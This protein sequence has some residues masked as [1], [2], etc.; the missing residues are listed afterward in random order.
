MQMDI[1]MLRSQK[2]APHMTFGWIIAQANGT[3]IVKGYGR[4]NGR[5]SSLR[6]EAAGIL[7]ASIFLGMIQKYT[8]YYLQNLQVK[9]M[10]DNDGLIRKEIEHLG[11][12]YPYPNITLEPE[13]DLVEEIYATHK[14]YQIT[15]SFKHVKGH[16]D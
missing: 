7:A 3:R 2:L 16:Q 6:A 8:N 15:A 12:T 14:K 1:Y 11:Y 13:F 9:F 10:A 5:A 4:C